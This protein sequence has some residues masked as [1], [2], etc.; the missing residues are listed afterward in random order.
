MDQSLW[1]NKFFT[2][3]ISNKKNVLFLRNWIRSGVRK[4]K[5][6]SFTNGILD[7]NNTYRKILY[8]D[9]I[10]CELLLV[11]NALLP[12]QQ[13][14]LQN[15]IQPSYANVPHSSKCF[16]NIFKKSTSDNISRNINSYLFQ[17]SLTDNDIE[18]A[19]KVKVKLEKEIKLKEFN[20]KMIYGILPCNKNLCKWR[21]RSTDT[22]DTCTE[23]QTIEHLLF[24]C[25]YVKPIWKKVD[26]IF[27]VN[28]TFYKILGLDS[29]F[30]L[31]SVVTLVSFLI[32]KEWLLLSYK[33]H[34]RSNTLS[35]T[36]FKH[37]MCLRLKIYS[38][39]ISISKSH[40]DNIQLLIE[41][42]EL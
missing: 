22:C 3:S 26:S 36:Y 18:N 13:A 39:C 1:G 35:F 8:K 40:Q 5:D 33:G 29:N 25:Q 15:S 28:L 34:R 4:V 23:V 27:K 21:I 32:Y 19:Y 41:S 14:I 9:N 10:Y 37:E 31:N 24:Q 42:L 38:K 11:K 2:H 6:L 12:F 20:F 7:T 30:D 17:F 16:Y